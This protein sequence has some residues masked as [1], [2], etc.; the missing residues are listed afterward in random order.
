MN[1]AATKEL[2][3]RTADLLE[4]LP[5]SSTTDLFKVPTQS[6]NLYHSR[7]D[8]DDHDQWIIIIIIVM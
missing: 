1:K 5:E 4:Q 8:F 2:V 6:A 3:R 7:K